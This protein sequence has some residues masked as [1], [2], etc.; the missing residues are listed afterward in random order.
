MSE[1]NSTEK[2]VENMFYVAL[3]HTEV[4]ISHLINSYQAS[5]V[6]D[7]LLL[8]L[9]YYLWYYFMEKPTRAECFSYL[10]PINA[11]VLI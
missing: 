11:V 2:Q 8:E 4:N 1:T 5:I 6:S 9:S 10:K 3:P 7:V